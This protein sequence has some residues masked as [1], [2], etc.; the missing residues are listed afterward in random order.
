MLIES[1]TEFAISLLQTLLVQDLRV[2]VSELSN[3]VDVLFKVHNSLFYYV[4]KNLVL[5]VSIMRLITFA[6]WQLASKPGAPDS[7]QQLV[8]IVKNPDANAAALSRFSVGKDDMA[9]QSRE[10][11]V[12]EYSVA[13]L[14]NPFSFFF[15]CTLCLKVMDCFKRYSII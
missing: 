4:I 9:K 11:K 10:K 7:L 1:A 12:A 6:K 14:K 5:M 15:V 13:F 2:G 3:L 8:E